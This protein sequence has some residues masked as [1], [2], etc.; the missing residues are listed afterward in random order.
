[1]QFDSARQDKDLNFYFLV[2]ISELQQTYKEN[3]TLASLVE[4]S[5]EKMKE[6]S[7]RLAILIAKL[8]SR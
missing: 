7:K 1:M 8:L 3:R 2:R 6:L 4:Q 5:A